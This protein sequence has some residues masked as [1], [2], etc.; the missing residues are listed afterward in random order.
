MAEYFVGE[1]IE[2]H[3]LELQQQQRQQSE[4][5]SVIEEYRS[6]RRSSVRSLWEVDMPPTG[7]R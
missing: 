7:C 1:R 4:L 2:N 5:E 3:Q 6:G